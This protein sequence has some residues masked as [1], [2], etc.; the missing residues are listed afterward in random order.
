M[1]VYIHWCCV[2]SREEQSSVSIFL[3]GKIFVLVFLQAEESNSPNVLEH[4]KP[5]CQLTITDLHNTQENKADGSIL[6]L[7]ERTAGWLSFAL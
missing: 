4:C 2:K 5:R 7:Q 3:M 6:A 1:E